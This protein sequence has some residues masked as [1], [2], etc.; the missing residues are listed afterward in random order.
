VEHLPEVERAIFI[1]TPHRGSYL[2]EF[3]PVRLVSR[4]ITL[5]AALAKGLGQELT[6]NADALTIDPSGLRIGSL[7]GMTP[8]NLWIQAMAQLPVAPGIHAYSIIPTLGAGPLEGRS[9]GVVRYTSAHL[10]GVDSEVVIASSHAFCCCNWAKL[11][12]PRRLRSLP[13]HTDVTCRRWTGLLARGTVRVLLT[14]SALLGS[15][16]L[17]YSTLQPSWL[18]TAL[19]SAMVLLASIMPFVRAL[20]RASLIWVGWIHRS[21][22]SN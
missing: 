9:D 1:A 22:C 2:T 13:Q 20:S 12:R 4:L 21:R 10:E 14:L 15:M 8:G 5:P 17:Y 3:S 18:R 11:S 7:Y 16:A 6:G 19:A